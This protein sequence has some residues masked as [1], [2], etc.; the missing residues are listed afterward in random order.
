MSD[1]DLSGSMLGA[2]RIEALIGSGGMA[3]VY[4][5]FDTNLQRP[6]AIKVLSGRAAAEPGF[7]NRF[8]Q[9]ARMI[10]SLRHAHIVHVYDLGDAHG[11]T[12]MVQELLPGP[13]LADRIERATAQGVRLER[14]EIVTI[15]AHLASALDAAHAA[16]I[17]HRDV[18]PANAMWNAVGSLV[19]TDFGIAKNTLAT[20]NQT[21]IGT[22]L[23]TPTY[24]APEQA[25]G[26]PPSP[27]SDIY[28]L[29]VVLYELIT[30]VVPFTGVTPMR[31]LLSHIQAPP[32]PL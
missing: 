5:G 15:T 28:A 4:R 9:E 22:V 21:Q 27:A 7:A 26:L 29:G 25:Q 11:V 14:Q 18:K 20:V 8:Q 32:P 17:I 10:A 6:V 2:Y 19:L 24:L 13:T 31:V 12:Y 3:S 30:G 16:G 23:G 1:R